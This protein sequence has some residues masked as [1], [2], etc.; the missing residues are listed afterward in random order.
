MVHAINLSLK[1]LNVD[2]Y[3]LSW[4]LVGDSNNENLIIQRSE[5]PSDGY[6]DIAT[7]ADTVIEYIDVEPHSTQKY[8]PYYYRIQNPDGSFS[9]IVNMPYESNQQV[10][11]YIWNL[12]R[13][14]RR[15]GIKSYYFRR[16][17]M[18]LNCVHCWD[19]EL[20]KSVDQ[21]CPYCKGTGVGYGYSEPV[22]FYMMYPGD[23]PAI[24][25]TGAIKYNI[26]TPR[27]WTIGYP[28]LYP[29]DVVMRD[30]DKEMFI[31]GPSVELTT[32]QMF[33]VRQ[34]VILQAIERGSV[35][36]QLISGM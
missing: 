23:S 34:A 7:L 21:N 8:I 19:K 29:N 12:E 18:G 22:E 26:L 5:S 17:K 35:E 31:V 33:I 15:S 24:I 14:L 25:D 10:L 36:V 13:H 27:S 3:Q 9:A 30:I 6:K 28:R 16:I 11:R 4:T 1:I 2:R 20:R 32:K